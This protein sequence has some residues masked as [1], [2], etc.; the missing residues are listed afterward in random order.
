MREARNKWSVGT[1]NFNSFYRD[2]EMIPSGVMRDGG[3]AEYATLRS[4]SLC[5]VPK[6]LDP[7]EAAPLLCAGIT[8][9][10]ECSRS[11]KMLFRP[12]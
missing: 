12:T 7:A 8:A 10:S 5:Q 6:E 3:Y 11:S 2:T 4:I 1:V 9:F